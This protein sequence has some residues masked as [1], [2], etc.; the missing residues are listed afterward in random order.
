MALHFRAPRLA[1]RAPTL[2][3]RPKAADA[4][5]QTAEYRAWRNGVFKRAGGR[6]QVPGCG[7][8]EPRMFADHVIERRDGGALLDPANGMLMCGSHHSLKTAAK[9]AERMHG[10]SDG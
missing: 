1:H 9:R 7:R 6:C 8:S 10:R 5:L 2:K 4:E 3:P